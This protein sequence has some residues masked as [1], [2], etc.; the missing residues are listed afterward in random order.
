VTEGKIH[1][2]CHDEPTYPVIEDQ[3]IDIFG[4]GELQADTKCLES[5]AEDA[6]EL[7]I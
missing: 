4:E 1:H 2:N 7:R 5:F 6:P 3:N